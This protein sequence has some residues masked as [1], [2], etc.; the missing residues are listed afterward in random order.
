[1]VALANVTGGAAFGLAI[2]N[3]PPLLGLNFHVQAAVAD[4]GANA[5]GLF[6]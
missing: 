2:P 6:T 5:G 4:P 1:M 3:A